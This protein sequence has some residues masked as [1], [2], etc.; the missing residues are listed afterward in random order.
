M[1]VDAD[2]NERYLL[3]MD[4]HIEKFEKDRKG[5]KVVKDN[6]PTLPGIE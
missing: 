6:H 1:V 3:S 2:D 5:E 4:V